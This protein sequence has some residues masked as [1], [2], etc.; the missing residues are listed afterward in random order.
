MDKCD[1]KPQSNLHVLQQNNCTLPYVGL[2]TSTNKMF[3]YNACN[4]ARKKKGDMMF[5][6]SNHPLQRVQVHYNWLNPQSHLV[7]K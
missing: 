1:D 4:H 3:G 2:L 7:S 6:T 5:V